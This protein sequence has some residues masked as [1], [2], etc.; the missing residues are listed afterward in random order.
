[1]FAIRE[2]TCFVLVCE[3]VRYRGLMSVFPAGMDRCGLRVA[4]ACIMDWTI[5]GRHAETSQLHFIPSL[6]TK[7]SQH[8]S[9]ANMKHQVSSHDR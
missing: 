4:P 9:N 8:P 6:Y 3:R 2:S 7:P 1:M 5:L